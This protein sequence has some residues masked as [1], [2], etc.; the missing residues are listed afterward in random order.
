MEFKRNWKGLTIFMIVIVLIVSLMPQ[1]YPLMEE[2]F[3]EEKVGGEEFVDLQ[4]EDNTI[5]LSW[6]WIKQDVTDHYR[7]IEDSASH[8]ATS[9]IVG[10]PID[11]SL[12]LDHTEADPENR[13]FAV[14]AIMTDSMEIPIGMNSTV[15]PVDPIE[16][17]MDTPYVRI[18]TGGRTDLRMDEIDGFMSV[19]L[20]SWWILLVGLYLAYISVKSIGEDYDKKRMDI[21][22]STPLSKRQYLLEKFS[23]LSL[24]TL[25]LL[26]IAGI[27]MSLSI[28]SIGE[29]NGIGAHALVS[30]MFAA[31][32]MF[33][34]IIAVAFLLA[35]LLKS[36]RA[37]VGATFGFVIF[38]YLLNIIGHM[39]EGLDFSRT[40]TIANYWDYNSV[41]LDNAFRTGDFI[42]LSIITGVILILSVKL[43][44]RSDIPS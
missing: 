9:R 19:E 29:L 11:K 1:I 3:E 7:V 15:D 5:T 12:T 42:L 25:A 6:D 34:V 21:I 33:L 17:L 37:A 8:M 44:E 41:L 4:L 26:I 22:F 23:A 36:S 43:F 32:P 39:V 40:Y 27:S 35:L 38:Q 20:Y 16:E 2:Q 24:F 14:I 13:Y 31:W 10:E 18:F 30:S 28:Y